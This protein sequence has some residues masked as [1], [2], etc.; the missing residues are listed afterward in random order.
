MADDTIKPLQDRITKIVGD[1]ERLNR[2]RLSGMK[3]KKDR[4]E[5]EKR[6]ETENLATLE[7]EKNHQIGVNTEKE[8]TF[9][10]A[11]R[12]EG[13]ELVDLSKEI[14][15]DYI[16]EIRHREAAKEKLQKKVVALEAKLRSIEAVRP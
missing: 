14:R 6:T 7:T 9:Q 10:E 3:A 1:E 12:K 8:R 13:E 16:E 11:L 4:R 2:N 15:N 5:V